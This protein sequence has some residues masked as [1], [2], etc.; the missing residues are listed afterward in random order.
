MRWAVIA[1]ILLAFVLVP[2]AL[3]GEDQA[4][5]LLKEARG[6]WGAATLGLLLALDIV[7]PIPS[8][9]VSTACGAL[10]GFVPGLIISSVGMTIAAAAGYFIGRAGALQ[11]QHRLYMNRHRFGR[12][13]DV[14]LRI[15]GAQFRRC[16]Q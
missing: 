3:L 7:L 13:F 8:S 2:F 6:P 5:A 12:T 9:I 10:F 16:F 14:P 4:T 1:V 11:V 15:A